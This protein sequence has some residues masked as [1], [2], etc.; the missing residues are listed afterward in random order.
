MIKVLD[1]RHNLP[2]LVSKVLNDLAACQSSG[3]HLVQDVGVVAILRHLNGQ[4]KGGLHQVCLPLDAR[5]ELD[6]H[7]P[8][9]LARI[10]RSQVELI[11]AENMKM[12][13]FTRHMISLIIRPAISNPY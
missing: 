10:Y 4:L 7:R 11:A 2:A 6:Q 3:A 13:R 1:I 12:K 8:Q 9:R 5:V